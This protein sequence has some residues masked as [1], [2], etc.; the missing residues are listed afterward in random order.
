MCFSPG[1][2]QAAHYA[3]TKPLRHRIDCIH[4]NTFRKI[5]TNAGLIPRVHLVS[6]MSLG[7]LGQLATDLQATHF[8]ATAADPPR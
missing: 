5:L 2:R 6:T 4:Q 3:L 7:D 1:S 8:T